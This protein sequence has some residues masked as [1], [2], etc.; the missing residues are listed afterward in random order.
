M[1]FCMFI[2]LRFKHVI[3]GTHVSYLGQNL[4]LFCYL[5]DCSDREE[6]VLVWSLAGAKLEPSIYQHTGSASLYKKEIICYQ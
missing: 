3:L 5:L 2:Y 1:Y 6:R 4:S